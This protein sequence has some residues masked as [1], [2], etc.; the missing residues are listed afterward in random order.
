MIVMKKFK[1]LLVLFGTLYFGDEVSLINGIGIAVVL[2]ASFRLF[3][4]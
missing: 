2:A 4:T 3:V 1:V